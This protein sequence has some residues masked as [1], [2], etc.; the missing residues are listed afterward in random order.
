MNGVSKL[1]IKILFLSV[2]ALVPNTYINTHYDPYGIYRTDFTGQ[3]IE[4]NQRF[5]KVRY[6][7]DNPDKYD[8][9]IFGSSRVGNIPN[10]TIKDGKWYNMTISQGIPSEHLYNLKLLIKNGVKIKTV[11]LG[12]EDFSYKLESPSENGELITT[13]YSE[14]VVDNIKYYIR[15]TFKPPKKEIL[16]PYINPKEETF[17]VFYDLFNT[18]RPIH[19][20]IDEYIDTHKEEHIKDKK[21]KNPSVHKT[22]FMEQTLKDIQEFVDICKQNTIKCTVF[23]NPTYKSTYLAN[24]PAQFI[25]FKKRLVQITDFYDFSGINS[26]TKDPF[27][28]Y[29]TSHYRVFIGEKM[30]ARMFDNYKKVSVPDDFGVLVSK[31]NIDAHIKKLKSQL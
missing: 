28:Y 31:N 21:F 16:E 17:P 4:P 6:L 10:E 18:G 30:L 7:L 11:M 27:N 12:L 5:I 23:I 9:Y 29:E 14:S 2:L 20:E 3:K 24:N 8:S 25:E 13:P 22:E 26:V 15:Y 19:T 1:L